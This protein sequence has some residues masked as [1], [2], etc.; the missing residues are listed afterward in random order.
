MVATQES[1]TPEQRQIIEGAFQI[2]ERSLNEVLLPRPQVFVLDAELP[3]DE[4]LRQLA[5]SGHSRAPVARSRNLDEVVGVVR[6]RQLLD[7]GG[8]LV[9][10]LAEEV[11]VL[12]ESAGV[13]DALRH[14]Q[15]RRQQLALVANEHGG[16]EGIVTVEDLVEEVVGEIYDETDR[17]VLSA[18]HN[19]DGTLTLPGRFPVHDLEDVGVELPEGPYATVAGLVLERLGRIPEVPGDVVVVD[20]WTI[21]V[22]GVARHTITEVR[23]A[24]SADGDDQ[25]GGATP[26]PDSSVSPQPS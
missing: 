10:E 21:E 17:D 4:A 9:R 6:L 14:L 16:I 23:L 8:R 26:V 24:E 5:D 11:P 15:A 12:P 20:G 25:Q 1:F 7:G 22:T 18:T 3:S 19:A 2:A 13:L